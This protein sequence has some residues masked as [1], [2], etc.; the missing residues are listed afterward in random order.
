M[1]LMRGA[2]TPDY[3][4]HKIWLFRVSSQLEGNVTNPV[5]GTMLTIEPF[6][7]HV[8]E[9]SLHVAPSQIALVSE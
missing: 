3:G 9:K 5:I 8:I 7:A 4:E 2:L 1:V 6:D